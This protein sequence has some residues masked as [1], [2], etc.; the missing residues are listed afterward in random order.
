MFGLTRTS[1]PATEP[2]TT[3]E[4]KAYLRQDETADDTLIDSL[5]TS[6]REFA[7]TYTG[8]TFVTSTWRLTLD[9]WPCV[10][11]L[12]MGPVQAI[13]SIAYLDGNG[14]SQTLSSSAYRLD[15]NTARI[16]PAYGYSWP[17]VRDTTAPITITYTAGFGTSSAVPLT[18]KQ[19]IKF[20]VS[21]WY[22]ERTPIVTSG[23][24]PKVLPLAVESLLR[25]HW[26][27]EVW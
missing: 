6:A 7:E 21:H 1:G 9:T 19:A 15:A 11:L 2:I 13:S 8:R 24:V 12:P 22:E 14:T 3:T 17:T 26:Q 5:I 23:A 4:A 25:S 10:V 18:L 16:T 27:G 20:L